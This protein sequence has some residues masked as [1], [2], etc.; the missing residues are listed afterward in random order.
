MRDD[1]LF[2]QRPRDGVSEVVYWRVWWLLS[3]EIVLYRY[4]IYPP[5]HDSMITSGYRNSSC[6]NMQLTNTRLH[7][8][9]FLYLA[10]R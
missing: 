10:L 2:L 1:S 3:C 9:D 4:W 7:V 6:S 5:P 8:D